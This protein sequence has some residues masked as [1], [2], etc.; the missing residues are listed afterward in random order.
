MLN[1]LE[2]FVRCY[3]MVQSGDNIVCAVSGGADSIALLFALYLLREKLKINLAAAHF[4]H[5]LRG[6]E[7]DSDALFVR[8]FCDQYDIPLHMG[9]GKVTPGKKGLEASARDARYAF[10]K[11]LPGKIATA[12]TA[13]DNA[14]TVLM[15]MVRGTGLKGLGGI[16]PINGNLIRP[17]LSITRAEVCVFLESY[18]LSYVE[19]SSNQTDIFMRNRFRHRVM[20]LLNM[21]N[22]KFAENI[23]AMALRLRQDESALSKLADQGE[24]SVSAL[25]NQ[26]PA[27]RRRMIASFLENNGVPELESQHIELVEQLVFSDKPS[28]RANLPGGV[29]VHRSYDLLGVSC[30]AEPMETLKLSCPGI[31][32]LPEL[33]LRVTCEYAPNVVNTDSCFTVIPVGDLT[34]RCRKAG[35]VMRL[36]GGTK[37]LKKLFIDKKIPAQQRLQIP[38]VVDDAGILCVYGVGVNLDRVANRLPAVQ[39]RFEKQRNS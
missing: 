17:M 23:S 39:I 29:V 13:D 36:P 5:Q 18:H 10:L 37:E 6:A 3:D 21:E 22:P 9:T 20:P 11:Q 31:T 15:H 34:L 16:T 28:A 1:K 14:E 2:R 27:I 35:D 30:N 19:D 32:E 8:K 26:E 25:R 33:G 24:W 4:N 38:V 7:S 12:H